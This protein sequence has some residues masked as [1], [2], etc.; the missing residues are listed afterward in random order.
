MDIKEIER[1]FYSYGDDFNW[2]ILSD[3][4]SF[5]CELEKE[6]SNK[7]PLHNISAKAIAKCESNDDVLFVLEDGR[8]V[9][10]HLTYSISNSD[11]YPRVKLFETL[12]MAIDFIINEFISEY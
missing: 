1:L 12:N 10:V 9:I 11:K 8:G 3:G 4:K 7:H 5:E 2:Y 6:I